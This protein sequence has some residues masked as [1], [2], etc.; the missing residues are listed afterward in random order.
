MY[1]I[2]IPLAW[3]HPALA[4]VIYVAVAAIWFVPDRRMESVLKR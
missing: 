4:L 3:L 1:A 2:A